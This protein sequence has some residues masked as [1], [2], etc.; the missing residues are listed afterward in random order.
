MSDSHVFGVQN[1][2][3][4]ENGYCCVL[5]SLGEVYGLVVYL[6]SVGLEQHQR[7]QSGKLHPGSP[8][9]AFLQSRLDRVVWRSPR[10]QPY[11]SGDHQKAWSKIPRQKYLA[12]ISRYATWV[13]AV[14]SR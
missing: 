14:A 10:S 11:G 3:D 4:G 5:G 9:F 12:A 7:M 1:P 8:D 2:D 6:G 13:H